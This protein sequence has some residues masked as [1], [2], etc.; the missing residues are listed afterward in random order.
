MRDVATKLAPRRARAHANRGNAPR[1][2]LTDSWRSLAQDGPA[3]KTELPIGYLVITSKRIFA[4]TWGG[5]RDGKRPALSANRRSPAVTH[6]EPARHG[7]LRED[8]LA[9][10]YQITD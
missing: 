10:N 7:H 8:S 9:R 4:K 6:R 5:T 2:T 1:L 3:K